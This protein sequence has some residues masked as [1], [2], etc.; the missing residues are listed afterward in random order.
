MN[1]SMYLN[2][3]LSNIKAGGVADRQQPNINRVFHCKKAYLKPQL[4]QLPI[5]TM[6]KVEIT[7]VNSDAHRRARYK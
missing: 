1:Q 3:D 5:K 6:Q 4:G 7:L 2:F